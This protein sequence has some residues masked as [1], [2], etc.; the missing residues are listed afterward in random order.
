MMAPSRNVTQPSSYLPPTMLTAQPF[1][2]AKLGNQ[3]LGTEQ[4]PP[5]KKNKNNDTA[6]SSMKPSTQDIQQ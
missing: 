6:I 1:H 3:T 2:S 5:Y 4:P